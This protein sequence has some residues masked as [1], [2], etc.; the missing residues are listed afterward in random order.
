MLEDRTLLSQV[1]Y[2]LSI[3]GIPGDSTAVG[4]ESA[5]VASSTSWDTMRPDDFVAGAAA[6]TPLVVDS[7]I[8]QASPKLFEAAAAATVYPTVTLTESRTDSGKLIDFAT[9]TLTSAVVT[10]YQTAGGAERYALDYTKADLSY[11][12]TSASGNLGTPV[13][14]SWDLAAQGGTLTNATDLAPEGPTVPAQ[15]FLSIPGVSGDS[16]AAGHAH[17]I[18]ALSMSFG[19]SA[20]AANGGPSFAPL[21]IDSAISQASPLLF[22]AAAAG[23]V[24]PTVTLSEAKSTSAELTTFAELTLSNVAVT[25]YQT[26]DGAERYALAY[27]QADWSFLPSTDTGQPGTP[28]DAS[29]DLAAQGGTLAKAT[30]LA[31]AGPAIDAQYFLAVPGVPGDSTAV[32]HQQAISVLSNSFGVTAGSASGNP[33]FAPLVVDSS[34]NQASPLLF[35]AAAAGTVYSTVTL[36]AARANQGA[37]STFARLVLT[38]VTVTSYQTIAGAERYVLAYTAAEWSYIPTSRTGGPGSPIDA[39]WDL[40]TQGGTLAT[41]ADLT[42]AGPTV[43]ALYFLTVP[44]VPGDST[45]VGHEQEIG[46]FSMGFGVSTGAGSAGPVLEPL[47]VDSTISE[48]SP[49]LFEA[50]AA[51]TQYPTVTLTAAKFIVGEL[52]TFANLVLSDVTIVSY[53]TSGGAERYALNYKEADFSFT[54][55]NDLGQPGTPV[56]ASWNLTAQGGTLAQATDLAPSAPAVDASYFLAVPGVSGDSA[57]I[58]HEHTIDASSM[59]FGV[60]AGSV[61]G[62]PSFAPLVVDSSIGRASPLLFESAAAGTVYSTVTLTVAHL[63]AGELTTFAVLSLSNVTITSYETSDGAERYALN[64]TAADWSYV[65]T[66]ASGQPGS[67]IDASW[68]LASQG[69]TLAAAAKLTP[70]GSPVAA[71]YFLAVPGVA[72]DSTADAHIGAID[73]DSMSWS[74]SAGATSFAPLIVSASINQASPLLFLSVAAG[75][76]YPVVTLSAARTTTGGQIDFAE[77]TLNNVVF[78]KYEAADGEEEYAFIFTRAEFKYTPTS[79]DGSQG[80]P[81]DASFA[82]KADA[83]VTLSNLLQTYDGQP[84]FATAATTPPDLDV[85]FLY[86]QNGEPVTSPIAAGTYLVTATVVDANYQGTATGSLVINQAPLSVSALNLSKVFGSP[87]PFLAYQVTAGALFAGDALSGTLSRAAGETIGTYAIGQGTLTA[88]PNYALVFKPAS[89]TITPAKTTISVSSSTITSVPGQYVTYTASIAVVAPGAG[90]PIGT[91][92]FNDGARL[93]ATVPVAGNQATYSAPIIILGAHTISAVFSPTGG[94]YASPGSPATLVQQVQ[95]VALES[96]PATGRSALDVGS[97]LYDDAITISIVTVRNG[98]DQYSVRIDTQNGRSSTSVTVKGAA[99]GTIDQVIAFGVGRS[100]FITVSCGPSVASKLFGGPGL[101]VLRGGNGNNL[102]VGGAG[103]NVL[104]GGPGRNILIGGS[105]VAALSAGSG[106]TI[107][108]AGSTTF[109]APTPANLAALDQI[110]AEWASSASTAARMA[111]ISGTAAGG[112]NGA[113]FLNSVTVQD[114]GLGDLAIGG[115]GAD[116]FFVDPR[117][118]IVLS[119]KSDTITNIRGW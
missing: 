71:Q 6:F 78:T 67:P 60:A 70:A 68:N 81:V 111:H 77:W 93:L 2:F 11:T 40:T 50:A 104:N 22:Q 7:S 54:P 82:F 85:T 103:A 19:V 66:T 92:T 87:D 1:D 107:L 106:D 46:A 14:A 21:L 101:N 102:L 27:T 116:W 25:S 98:N 29:W 45:A 63:E 12:P 39:S 99:H 79:S 53:Q 86:S 59:S 38:N 95:A 26:L 74:V 80:P 24:Y 41:A 62:N 113:N 65:P 69:G 108:I 30:N 100:D 91:V 94:N 58:G 10:S 88:G 114:D 61:P 72:G 84:E 110:M 35:Q 20:G 34:I 8:S 16:T 49:L 37:L 115:G 96:D 3:P 57:A 42:P 9:W 51:G 5:I 89:L 36:A 32:G 118:S 33:S 105:G 117:K 43:T 112:L 48:V 47:L 76:V 64:Y 23:T 31:P 75:T 97:T 73:V 15:Y 90:S 55:S 4:H 119:K 17:S 109:D 44:G 52:T 83:N 13:E 56:D 18:G 28:V